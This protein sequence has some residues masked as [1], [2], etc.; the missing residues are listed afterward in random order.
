MEEIYLITHFL[1][2]VFGFVVTLF[3]TGLWIVGAM[4][5]FGLLDTD[6]FFG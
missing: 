6:L 2:V 5:V 1:N 4:N 3:N